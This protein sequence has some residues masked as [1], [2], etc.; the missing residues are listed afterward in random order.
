MTS[1]FFFTG[2]VLQTEISYPNIGHIGIPILEMRQSYDPV[3]PRW[4]FQC[5]QD[6]LDCYHDI[7]TALV[8]L[9]SNAHIEIHFV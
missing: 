4:D 2:P 3:I 9:P 6:N 8:A 7:D 1:G 5:W